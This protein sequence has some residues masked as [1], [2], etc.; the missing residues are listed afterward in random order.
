[1]SQNVLD[2]PIKLV[3]RNYHHRS[4]QNFSSDYKKI[5]QNDYGRHLLII[6]RSRHK[7]SQVNE[8]I[9]NTHVF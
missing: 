7:A 9:G 4:R 1:M 5:I 6:I 8:L 3:F 2:A